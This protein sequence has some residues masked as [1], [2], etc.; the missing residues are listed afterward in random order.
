MLGID[1]AFAEVYEEFWPYCKNVISSEIPFQMKKHPIAFDG[2]PSHLSVTGIAKVSP[3]DVVLKIPS[4]TTGATYGMVQPK[5][6]EVPPSGHLPKAT[7]EVTV[8]PIDKNSFSDGGDS[9]A[10]VLNGEGGAVV[11]GQLDAITEL[12]LPGVLLL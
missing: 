1:Y 7:H 12:G 2:F 4:R 8:T 3:Y 11:H 9:G 10:A 5:L 6:R